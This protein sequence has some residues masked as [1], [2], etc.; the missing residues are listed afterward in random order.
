VR[1]EI[2]NDA[3]RVAQLKAGQLD[4]IT[5]V[6][7]SDVATLERDPKVTVAKVDTV[8]VF[9]LEMD[10]RE[11]PPAGQV[12]AKDGSALSKNP[13]LESARTR[14][15]ILRSTAR[16][17]P[18]AW[19]PRQAGEPARDAVDLR[20]Q[21]DASQ[22][23][24]DVAAAKKLM[25]DAGYPNG[26]RSR[27]ASQDRLPGAA[28]SA[29]RSRRCS[30]IGISTGERAAGAVPSGAD[31]RGVDVHVGLG[32]ADRRSHYSPRSATPT[33]RSASSAPSTSGYN[34]PRWT[35]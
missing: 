28:R 35:S 33:T 23:K 32:H 14:R 20:L 3:S 11:Q 24:Y 17:L 26:F 2:P 22:R 15:S 6:P 29:P 1:K 25:A 13:Y 5:R 34:N 18:D 10:M 31:A 4:L 9:N 19:R 27:S 7:A 16:R 21:Q 30:A 12:S 8:Y